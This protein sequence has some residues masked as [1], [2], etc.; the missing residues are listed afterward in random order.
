MIDSS[1]ADIH[2][3]ERAIQNCRDK[4]AETVKSMTKSHGP[5]PGHPE[6]SGEDTGLRIGE[7]DQPGF[8][9]ELFHIPAYGEN[10][11]QVPQSMKDRPGTAVLA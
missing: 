5:D 3:L 2:P 8:R 10:H 9:T 6:N 4:P 7:I 1:R 11:L